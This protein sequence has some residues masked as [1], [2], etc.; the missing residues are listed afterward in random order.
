MQTFIVFGSSN[1]ARDYRSVHGTGGWIFI[2]T[3]TDETTLF[4][5][6]FTPSQ[7]MRHVFTAGK[8]GVLN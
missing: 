2:E 8:D 1:D 5:L 4:P 7:I 6:D 3:S